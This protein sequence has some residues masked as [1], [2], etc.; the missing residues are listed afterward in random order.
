MKQLIVARHNEDISW[1]DQLPDGWE[2][3]VIQ[4]G[5]DLPN[6]GREGAS[7]LH[8]LAALRKPARVADQY[9]FVQGD[10]WPH[11]RRLWEELEQPVAWFKWLGEDHTSDAAGGPHHTGLPVRR[12]YQQWLQ[13]TWPACDQLNFAA[14]GQFVVSGRAVKAHPATFYKTLKTLVCS[15][16]DGP[17]VMERIWEA[18]F[19]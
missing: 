9:A 1:L 18:V 12:C 13:T 7:F 3:W 14:G 11:C 15:E 6:E 8:A 4:K 2:P 16:P 5:E 19:A 10:P 17:W